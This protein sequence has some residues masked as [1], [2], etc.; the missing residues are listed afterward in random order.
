MS[1][2]VVQFGSTGTRVVLALMLVLLVAMSAP[3]LAAED[4]GEVAPE[5]QGPAPGIE[6]IGTQN[7]VS[8]QYLPE[9]AEPPPFMRF[10]YVPLAVVGVLMIAGLL[11]LYLAWQPR[12]AEERR[13]KRRR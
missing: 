7:E 3:A 13:S 5:E 12:F 6:E 4:G 2:S 8:Q 10:L 11:F 9:P 1:R